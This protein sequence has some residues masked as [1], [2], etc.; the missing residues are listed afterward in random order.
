MPRSRGR[1]FRERMD[2]A[3]QPVSLRL[4]KIIPAT[5]ENT[6]LVQPLL[7]LSQPQMPQQGLL[8]SDVRKEFTEIVVC[9]WDKGTDD[10]ESHMHTVRKICQM[11]K[12]ALVV[13][14]T[15]M[16]KCKPYELNTMFS[17]KE[18]FGTLDVLTKDLYF[19]GDSLCALRL[20]ELEYALKEVCGYFH[21]RGSLYAEGLSA[22]YA[23]LLQIVHPELEIC[24]ANEGTAYE[25]VLYQK[26]YEDYNLS[27]IMLP[28]IAKYL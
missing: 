22:Q 20:Y 9:V 27:S 15:G 8:F 12:A 11:G 19:L 7:W 25:D 28:G 16:G 5:Q 2:F 14:L 10:L 24:T 17:A 26:Y 6:L 4:R 3:R 1:F 21:C 23:R 13:D 18:R